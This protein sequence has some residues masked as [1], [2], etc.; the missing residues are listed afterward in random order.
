MIRLVGHGLDQVPTLPRPRSFC[1]IRYAPTVHVLGRIGLQQI[2][3]PGGIEKPALGRL[4]VF[5]WDDG[6]HAIVNPNCLVSLNGDQRVRQDDLTVGCNELVPKA[7]DVKWRRIVTIAGPRFS[8]IERPGNVLPGSL[9]LL[10]LIK[11]VGDLQTSRALQKPPRERL[12]ETLGSRIEP[13][14]NSA[15]A[16]R[17]AKP[18]AKNGRLNADT[19]IRHAPKDGV[20]FVWSVAERAELGLAIGTPELTRLPFFQQPL[21]LA[22]DDVLH[23]VADPAI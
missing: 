16:A 21:D 12:G 20:F 10:R 8:L 22:S 18:Q 4:V 19:A 17:A 11:S 15:L 2:E 7:S 6:R 14:D 3:R 23:H 9:D 5:D 13:R 1:G